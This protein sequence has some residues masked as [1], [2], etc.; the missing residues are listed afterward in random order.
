[1]D[2]QVPCW[3]DPR[4]LKCNRL[5]MQVKGKDYEELV[6][7]ALFLSLSLSVCLSVSSSSVC[8]PVPCLCLCLPTSSFCLLFPLSVCLRLS[9]IFSCLSFHCL[10]VCPPS[11]SLAYFCIS[12]LPA[13][14]PACLSLSLSLSLSLKISRRKS[15][16]WFSCIV[17]ENHNISFFYYNKCISVFRPSVLQLFRKSTQ[18][19]LPVFP[20]PQERANYQRLSF[21]LTTSGSGNWGLMEATDC[22]CQEKGSKSWRCEE[23]SFM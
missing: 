7:I 21:L 16:H 4:D 22:L 2:C 18:L 13:R 5:P 1:M 23:I 17:S 15:V 11:L 14:L 19:H 6:V 10:P 9:L 3:F 8:L 12:S 20:S